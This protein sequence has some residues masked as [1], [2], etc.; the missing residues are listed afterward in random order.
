[1]KEKILLIIILLSVFT[2]TGCN[3]KK[4][5]KAIEEEK[6]E[7][8]DPTKLELVTIKNDAKD[9]EVVEVVKNNIVKVTNTLEKGTII[10]TGFFNT[11]G[12]LITC[13][14]VVD[15]K[16]K[17]TI[18][19][20]NGEK[21]EDVSIISNDIVSD[22]AILK[23]NNPK[24]RA[25]KLGSTIDLK[26]SDELYAIGYSY[27]L[28]GESTLVKGILSA[29]RSNAGIEYLQGDL[30]LNEGQSGGPMFNSKG[31][32][33]GMNTLASTNSTI[34]LAISSETLSNVIMKLK[35]DGKVEYVEGD[36]KT[37]A[38][39]NIL[40]EVGYDTDDMFNE[41]KFYKEE[42]KEEPKK[43]EQPSTPKP[44]VPAKSGDNTLKEF[45]IPG[46]T[47]TPAFKSSRPGEYSV[48]L[49]YGQK[50]ISPVI[51]TNH[52][53]ATYKIIG[54]I[55][56]LK[57]GHNEIKVR[58]TAENGA[59]KEYFVSVVV[60]RNIADVKSFEF[61]VDQAQVSGQNVY[62]FY[63]M[64]RDADGFHIQDDYLYDVV[65]SVNVKIYS[66]KDF[67]NEKRLVKEYNLTPTKLCQS[68]YDIAFS[69]IKS[70]LIEDDY[71]DGKV[72]LL[73]D[74]TIYTK[75]GRTLQK[76]LTITY[77]N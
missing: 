21:D 36:R 52:S 13:S 12:E 57:E 35:T 62:Q 49:K 45:T 19:Y 56:N 29:R 39:N 51:K 3:E 38:L 11:D 26:V 42:K 63:F 75:D 16:G 67:G 59:V 77:P 64:Y 74:V 53:K 69:S 23:V 68:Y 47:F 71:V 18:E 61:N 15:R 9:S 25:L 17:I 34:G 72:N 2:L 58:V 55:N 40:K 60:T 33:L 8:K 27:N 7:V 73:W 24:V 10:G 44:N 14:H 48:T 32:V 41:N 70:A 43:D 54:D 31:E 46:Y 4:E 22:V 5:E 30:S 66:T 65:K 28:E 20:P 6:E 1:M 76:E 50:S 37:N